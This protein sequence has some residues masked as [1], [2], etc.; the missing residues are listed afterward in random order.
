MQGIC[1]AGQFWEQWPVRKFIGWAA[2]WRYAL[3]TGRRYAFAKRII[4][5]PAVY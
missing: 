2:K 4:R 3:S 1:G 5:R